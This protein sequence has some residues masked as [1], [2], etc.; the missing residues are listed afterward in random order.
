MLR[1]AATAPACGHCGSCGSSFPMVMVTPASR[2]GAGSER[3]TRECEAQCL[4]PGRTRAASTGAMQQRPMGLRALW[5]DLTARSTSAA[6]LGSGAEPATRTTRRCVQRTVH[7]AL[8]ASCGKVGQ[9]LRNTEPTREDHRVMVGN[10]ELAQRLRCDG[11]ATVTCVGR[12]PRSTARPH[13]D[14]AARNPS[15]LCHDVTRLGGGLTGAVVHH[16]HLR[17]VR[18]VAL[19]VGAMR[20][21]VHESRHGL[22]PR[23]ARAGRGQSTSMYH[24]TRGLGRRAAPGRQPENALRNA[25]HLGDL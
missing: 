22:R 18:R 11:N 19:I 4:A 3:P 16:V 25:P 1:A 8:V 21:E 10:R 14:V 2:G 17:R 7:G 15:G 9:V 20:R 24:P 6:G 5:K 12:A 13:L 23:D